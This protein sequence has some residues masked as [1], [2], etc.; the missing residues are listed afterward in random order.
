MVTLGRP[1]LNICLPYPT[2]FLQSPREGDNII[3]PIFPVESQGLERQ[4]K[5]MLL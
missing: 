1:A 4:L 5:A 2:G 3:V